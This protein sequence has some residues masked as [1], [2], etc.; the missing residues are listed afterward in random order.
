VFQDTRTAT[1]FVVL[2]HFAVVC[3]KLLPLGHNNQVPTTPR[4]DSAPGT[5]PSSFYTLVLKFIDF[6][7]SSRYYLARHQEQGQCVWEDSGSNFELFPVPEAAAIAG[8]S[9]AV[10]ATKTPDVSN[11]S[12]TGRTLTTALAYSDDRAAN[13]LNRSRKV[14][15][16]TE[17]E[18]WDMEVFSP[19]TDTSL[20]L[21]VSFADL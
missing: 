13:L 11:S 21:S 3:C 17:N 6:K 19:R 1:S 14:S 8:D 12:S 16:D 9:T 20:V 18:E 4:D 5:V 7:F 2:A 15:R 10:T